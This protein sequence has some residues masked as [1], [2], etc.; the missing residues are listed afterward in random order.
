[1]AALALGMCLMLSG[2]IVIQSVPEQRRV[3]PSLPVARVIIEQRQAQP[4]P[5]PVPRGGS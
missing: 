5:L 1:M 4:V 3:D 2:C